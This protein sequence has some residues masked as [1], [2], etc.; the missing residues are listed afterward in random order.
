VERVD[1]SD[2][3]T[4]RRGRSAN[5]LEAKA[6]LSGRWTFRDD[7]LDDDYADDGGT[8]MI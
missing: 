4:V 2:S 3:S 6:I 7:D 5:G 8:R 1:N